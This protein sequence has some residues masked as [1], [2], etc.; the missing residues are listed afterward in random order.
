MTK[1]LNFKNAKKTFWNVTL[2]DGTV[3]LVST[4]TKRIFDELLALQNGKIGSDEDAID[5]LYRVC[6]LVL[7]RNKA[8]KEITEDYLAETFDIE[9]I[10]L[11]F[12][13][14]VQFV[15]EIKNAKN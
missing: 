7:S 5:A 11:L 1:A 2:P 10:I 14:Y 4:P 12:N 13:G 9:D 8:G 15:Q 6:A 3:L